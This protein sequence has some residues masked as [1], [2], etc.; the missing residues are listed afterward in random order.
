MAYK[1]PENQ[2]AASKRHY[3]QNKGYYLAR[4]RRYRKELSDYINKIKEERP[5]ADCKNNYPYYV[6]DFD[7]LEGT[8]KAGIVSYFCKTGRIGAMKQEVLKCEV[9]C[10]NCHRM[11]THARLQK[12]K[13]SMPA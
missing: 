5:C 13:E 9:V 6:M 12:I 8:A 2:R 1:N 7:H 3:E 10:S 11:R 4:N